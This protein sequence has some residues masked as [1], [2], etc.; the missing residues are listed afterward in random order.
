VVIPLALPN[1]IDVVF[2]DVGGPIYSDDN[3]RSAILG[4]L[5]DL[6]SD[7]GREPVD[8][9]TF[10]RLYDEVRAA[11]SGGL[12]RTLARELLGDEAL[13]HKLHER[14][15]RHWLH[16]PGSAYPDALELFKTLHGHVLVGVVAN[17]EAATVEALRR[18]GFED[19]IDIWGISA[20][21]GFEKPSREFFEWALAEARTD[22]A[23]AVHIGNRLD[24]DV[25]PAKALGMGT[26]W[27]TRG[28]APAEPTAEQ[29]A[30]ADLSVPDLTSLAGEILPRARNGG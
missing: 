21:V 27:V 9:V 16:P 15:G 13:R 6:R 17:Q 23:H 11:Q 1:R 24:T 25:R 26:I 3:F 22:A 10:E 28:E 5:D 20:L 4:A 7:Q 14:T 19:Y 12:R 8:R 18:D 29:L 30:E 2:C